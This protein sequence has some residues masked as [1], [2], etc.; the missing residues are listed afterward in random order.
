[1]NHC[2][3]TG[4]VCRNDYSEGR[5]IWAMCSNRFVSHDGGYVFECKR[6]GYRVEPDY[7]LAGGECPACIDEET[8]GD[9]DNE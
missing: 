5:Y 7:P 9:I 6:C 2:T 3:D 8:T 1:M 4:A